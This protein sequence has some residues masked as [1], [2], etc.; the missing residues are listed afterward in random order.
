MPLRRQGDAKKKEIANKI[1]KKD[2][3][4]EKR[5]GEGAKGKGTEGWGDEKKSLKEP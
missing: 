2:G 5:K 3:E 4:E 1:K